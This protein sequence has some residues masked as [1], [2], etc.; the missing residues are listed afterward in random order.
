MYSILQSEIKLGG[1]FVIL[2]PYEQIRGQNITVKIGL[3]P[4]NYCIPGRHRLLG[5][6]TKQ[7]LSIFECQKP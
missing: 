4:E 2:L 3:N 5:Q 7:P 1:N 6:N